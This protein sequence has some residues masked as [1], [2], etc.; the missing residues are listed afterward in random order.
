MANWMV[1]NA[2]LFEPL[3]MLLQKILLAQNI[4][5]TEEITLKF[6]IEGKVKV[7]CCSTD[8]ID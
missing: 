8:E 7:I 3:Y 5:H 1:E 4:I 2:T 6:I